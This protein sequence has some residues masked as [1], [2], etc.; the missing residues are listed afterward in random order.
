MLEFMDHSFPFKENL[1]F[2][3][4]TLQKVALVHTIVVCRHVYCSPSVA[5]ETINHLPVHVTRP[6]RV[7]LRW[8]AAKKFLILPFSCSTAI[9]AF[10]H[11]HNTV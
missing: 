4:S 6:Y 9:T 3:Y 5:I 10:L 8:S 1:Y 7:I 11:G 2:N